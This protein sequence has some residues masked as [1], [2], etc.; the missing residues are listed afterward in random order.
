MPDE[1]EIYE[2]FFIKILNQNGYSLYKDTV[3]IKKF[4]FFN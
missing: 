4:F 1:S 3:Y 2:H